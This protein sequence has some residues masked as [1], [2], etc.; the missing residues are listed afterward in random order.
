MMSLNVNKIREDFPL[1]NRK[2][3][4]KPI[5]Y[6][7]NA[8]MSLKPRQVIEKIN[9]YYENYPAC[10]GRSVH[11]LSKEAEEGYEGTRR[12]AQKFF[13]AR[14]VEEISFSKNTTESINPVEH[15]LN[16]SSGDMVLTTDKE[17]N[18]NL[19]PWIRLAKTKGIKLQIV[20]SSPDNTFDLEEF[21]EKVKGAKFVA[22]VHT[23]N[24]DGT[25]IPAKEVIKI[26]H[27]NNALVLLDAAQSAPHK[28]IDVKKLDVDFLACSGHKML[29]PTGTGIL[30]GK[31]DLLEKFEQFIIGGETVKNST[32]EDY[33]PENIPQRFEAGLQNYAG[34]IGL[35]AA[36]QYLKKLGLENINKH[37]NELNQYISEN[38]NQENKISLIGPQDPKLRSGIFSFTIQG[39]THHS[40]AQMLSKSNNIMMRSGAHCVHSW[41]NAHN[42]PG[43]ARA[44]L[45]LY[46][47]KEEADV[48]ISAIKELI[49]NF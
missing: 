32:Y 30:Y 43:S 2:I 24:I 31:K 33:T 49:K 13:N 35:G 47:T 40:I 20:K 6:F 27:D 8:C 17:H 23:S 16:L 38:L 14:K 44:S 37:E 36:L 39:L 1:F 5:I 15:N 48:F 46:N 26:S 19:L 42:S 9:E 11:T 41:F 28:P 7:D 4:G 10:V 3:N 21:K 18:S 45:Y 25:T 12:T 34:I 22:M 29:G